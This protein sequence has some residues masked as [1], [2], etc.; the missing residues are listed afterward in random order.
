MEDDDY[1]ETELD[2]QYPPLLNLGSADVLEAVMRAKDGAPNQYQSFWEL[3]EEGV[4]EATSDEIQNNPKV[5]ILWAAEN[6][7]R[8]IVETML[9]EDPDLVNARD[10]DDYTPLHRASYNGHDAIVRVLLARKADVEA[11]TIDGWQ[12]LHSA[13]RWNQ[14]EVVATLLQH[15]AP[16]NAQTNG[17]Q[18]ALHLAASERDSR[19]TL[20]VLLTNCNIDVSIRNRV[21]ETA[22]D[23]CR[24]TSEHCSLFQVTEDHIN[25]LH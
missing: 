19:A 22:H 17:G 13:S 12:P 11:R 18:T 15:G 1:D 16:I 5:R 4:D 14:A 21:G 6:N 3:D 9:A 7:E 23:I 24:R 25:S 2:Q 10:S 20:E 8:E